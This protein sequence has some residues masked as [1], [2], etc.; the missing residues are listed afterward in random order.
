MTG[1]SSRDNPLVGT[2]KVVSF[3]LEFQ[4]TGRRANVYEKPCGVIVATADRFTAVLADEA[5]LP[6]DAPNVLFDGMMAYSGRYRLQGDDCFV[7]TVDVA[8]HPTW[9]GTEQTRYFKLDGDTLSII[10]PPQQHPKAAG[11]LIRGVI[12]WKRE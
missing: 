9:L 4:D 1:T 11:Q 10:S 3:Q 8:W 6:G 2:W 5:R 7:T 12:V